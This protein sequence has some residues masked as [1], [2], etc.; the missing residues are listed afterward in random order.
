MASYLEASARVVIYRQDE[1]GDDV[2][3]YAIRVEGTDFWIDC[4]GTPEEAR[5]RA[6]ALGLT[7]LQ[8]WRESR[9][10]D[11]RRSVPSA[12]VRRAWSWPNSNHA[13][14]WRC[15][16]RWSVS[17]SQGAGTVFTMSTDRSVR[18]GKSHG[19]GTY[20]HGGQVKRWRSSGYG[21]TT[22]LEF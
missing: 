19:R 13:C 3:P 12:V 11:L 8:M 15:A 20:V 10:S 21:A 5:K 17:V 22:S 7:V 1:C 18:I 6:E 16:W 14:C 9:M 4:C 2:P